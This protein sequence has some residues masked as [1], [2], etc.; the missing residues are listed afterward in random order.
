[1]A[2]KGIF[3][4]NSIKRLRRLDGLTQLR[5]ARRLNV[6]PETIRNYEHGRSEPCGR[7][8]DQIWRD[9]IT[10]GKYD[11]TLFVDT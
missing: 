10:G 9:Y 1:M 11:L 7:V 2:R 8:V 4:P 5:L 6:T 3:N